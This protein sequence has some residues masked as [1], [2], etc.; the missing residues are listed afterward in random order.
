MIRQ[1][2]D[3]AD[4]EIVAIRAL[5]FIAEDPDRL[6]RF[7]QLTGTRPKTLRSGAGTPGF[8]SGVIQQVVGWEPWLLEFAAYAEMAPAEVVRAA[9]QLAE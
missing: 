1:A 8:L 4:P 3:Q 5:A 7:L 2:K 9:D 6:E